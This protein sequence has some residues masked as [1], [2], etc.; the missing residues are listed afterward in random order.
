[1]LRD[2]PL[3]YEPVRRVAR[4]A[5]RHRRHAARRRR[6]QRRRHHRRGRGA[7]RAGRDA[8]PARRPRGRRLAG[9]RLPHGRAGARAAATR[10]PSIAPFDADEIIGADLAGHARRV[11]LV[12]AQPDR[13]RDRRGGAA[14]IADALD[15]VG[16]VLVVDEVFRGIAVGGAVQPP[17]AGWRR[18]PSPSAAC[19]RCAASPGL[20]IGWVAGPPLL[21]DDVRGHHAAA[22]RCPAAACQALALLALDAPRALLRRTKPTSCTTTSSTSRR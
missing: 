17:A 6:R 11:P 18:T 10:R 16:G 12:A 2:V 19:P 1:M 9:A 15:R 13:H 22:S 21:V 7:G 20:R 5:R 8:D 14:R 4:A 3:G